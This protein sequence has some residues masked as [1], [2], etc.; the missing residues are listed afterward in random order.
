MTKF[1]SMQ[2]WECVTLSISA[3]SFIARLTD[4]AHKLPDEEGEFLL[5]EVP[6]SDLPLL[7]LGAVFYWNVG[8]IDALNGQRTRASVIRFRRLPVWTKEEIHPSSKWPAVGH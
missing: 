4:L 5:E 8:Y 1:V 6:R 2:K 3:D 7:K